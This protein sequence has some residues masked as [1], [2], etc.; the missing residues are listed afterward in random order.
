MMKKKG[1][2]RIL[3]A[4]RDIQKIRKKYEKITGKQVMTK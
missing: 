4:K 2:R 1:E 3:E